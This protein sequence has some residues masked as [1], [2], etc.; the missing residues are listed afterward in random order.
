MLPR[1]VRPP[2]PKR[3][4]YVAF[5]AA[6]RRWV[7]PAEQ[8]AGVAELGPVTRLPT[9]DP[10]LLGVTLH[11]GRAVALVAAD[12]GGDGDAPPARHL[13]ALRAGGEAIALPAEELVGLETVRG[14]GLPDGFELYDV[15]TPARRRRE[16]APAGTETALATAA[17]GA[18]S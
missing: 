13:V 3:R 7:L 14:D 16:A 8:V 17:P 10:A 11:R 15:E 2:Q 6:G 18:G 9:A 12:G 4:M 5:V 1:Q